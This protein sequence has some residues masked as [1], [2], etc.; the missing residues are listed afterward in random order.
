MVSPR[1]EKRAAYLQNGGAEVQKAWA[2]ANAAR[3]QANARARRAKDPET[4]RAKAREYYAKHKE[5]H[6]VYQRA[7]LAKN[8]DKYQARRRMWVME[9]RAYLIAHRK[10]AREKAKDAAVKREIRDQYKDVQR[11]TVKGEHMYI[12]QR[13]D[14]PSLYKIG[15]SSNPR[16]RAYILSIGQ[17]FKVAVVKIY[18]GEG[19]KE[20]PV[21]HRLEEYRV[22]G[23][24]SREWF[25]APLEVIYAAVG[26]VLSSTQASSS[27]TPPTPP[28]EP[29]PLPVQ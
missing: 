13:S 22:C 15:R 12:F 17:C 5:Q 3:I 10:S 25:R 20:L 18:E 4:S 14:E 11:P 8:K 28:E 1:K 26:H 2:K 6:A 21:Q 19:L 16:S 7:N 23:G 29:E 27:S 24:T 9:N